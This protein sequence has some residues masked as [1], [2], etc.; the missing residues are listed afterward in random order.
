M[1][2][3][4]YGIINNEAR[5]SE[6]KILQRYYC[7]DDKFVKHCDERIECYENA[8]KYWEKKRGVK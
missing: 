8:L 3:I 2:T 7:D 6:L 1:N 5:I 4:E